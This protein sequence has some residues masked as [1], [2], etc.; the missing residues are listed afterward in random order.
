MARATDPQVVT[1]SHDSTV[2]L[3]DITAGKSMCT[4]TNHKK[5]IRALVH[6]PKENTFA[7]GAP[8]NIKQWYAKDGKFI[9]NLSGHNAVINSLALN[10]DG[11]LAS[12]ADNGTLKFWDYRT[13][14]N[15]QQMDTI[16][17]PG[18]LDSESGI[19][20]SIFDKSGSRLITC[21]A[22]KTIKM[23]KEDAN[24]TEESDPLDWKPTIVRKSRF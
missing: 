15:F 8:D 3:W 18:S 19:F 2:R 4:L 5:S 9:Q 14:H 22:D 6:H 17:Q 21:E 23:Y 11:V 10:G 7:S 20:A 1:G 24:S 13:G 16:A 12:C